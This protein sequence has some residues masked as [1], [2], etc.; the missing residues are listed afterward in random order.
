MVGLV[1]HL[2]IT[3]AG[4]SL[5]SISSAA[6]RVVS[7]RP[8]YIGTELR[9]PGRLECTGKREPRVDLTTWAS[10]YV[11]FGYYAGKARRVPA[12]HVAP[13]SSRGR[14]ERN[15]GHLTQIA[16]F[17]SVPRT[18]WSAVPSGTLNVPVAVACRTNVISYSFRIASGTIGGPRWKVNTSREVSPSPT[19]LTLKVTVVSVHSL[20]SRSGSPN[21]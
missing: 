6:A 2:T 7:P 4:V 1:G 3:T 10:R 12:L 18:A 14:R 11:S 17:L 20:V 15:H 5:A 13:G 9:S 21:T 19:Q 8:I 16:P